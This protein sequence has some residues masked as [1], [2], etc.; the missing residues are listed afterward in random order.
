MTSTVNADR[1]PESFH[2]GSTGCFCSVRCQKMCTRAVCPMLQ[3]L[4]MLLC[5][6]RCEGVDSAMNQCEVGEEGVPP[7]K[8]TLCGEHD[9]Q[10]EAQ[11]WDHHLFLSTT[12][13]TT[14]SWFTLKPLCLL[15]KLRAAE[16]SLCW[17]W[18]WT[19]SWIQMFVCQASLVY[20][21]SL[22]LKRWMPLCWTEC[23]VF[24]RLSWDEVWCLC[25]DHF[26]F[27]TLYCFH[28]RSHLLIFI[29]ILNP[30]TASSRMCEN[31]KTAAI[32]ELLSIVLISGFTL[33]DLR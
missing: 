27:F 23:E 16:T 25:P 33:T 9:S 5:M 22:W 2:S 15:L 4:I 7:S 14:P 1:Q 11:R 13:I 10:T 17:T 28:L 8:I 32:H 29:Q 18:T 20:G 6:W 3:W 21:G 12:H 30:Q 19:W 31:I 26:M 24:V